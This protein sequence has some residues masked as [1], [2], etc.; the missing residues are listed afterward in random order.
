MAYSLRP[1]DGGTPSFADRINRLYSSDLEELVQPPVQ[2]LSSMYNLPQVV[3]STKNV[4][5]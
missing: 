2:E 3:D 1:G 4:G 5:T